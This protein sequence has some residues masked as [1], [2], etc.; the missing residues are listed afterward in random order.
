MCCE[1]AVSFVYILCENKLQG[2]HV[3]VVE[4]I[5]VWR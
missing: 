3:I 2:F 5:D 1:V 4:E